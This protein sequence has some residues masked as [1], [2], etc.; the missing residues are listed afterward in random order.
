MEA[1]NRNTK[2]NGTIQHFIEEISSTAFEIFVKGHDIVF[3]S[4]QCSRRTNSKNATQCLEC[5]KERVNIKKSLSKALPIG[6]NKI[7]NNSSTIHKKTNINYIA[8]HPISAGIRIRDDAKIIER[9]R[10][11]IAKQYFEIKMLKD[12]L[13]CEDGSEFEDGVIHVFTEA[14]SLF[15]G[16]QTNSSDDEEEKV[17]KKHYGRLD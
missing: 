7:N 2:Q 11:L 5:E 6:M 14:N 3:Y 12:L 13:R 8:A 4:K 16:F 9:Q 1:S 10:K 15:V 17:D